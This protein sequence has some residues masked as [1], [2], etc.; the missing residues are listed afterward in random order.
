MAVSRVGQVQLLCDFGSADQSSS[1]AGL[2]DEHREGGG[3]LRLSRYLRLQP[4]IFGW[5]QSGVQVVDWREARNFF[6]VAMVC[7]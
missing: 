1:H 7:Y 4:Q 3:G 5:P 6:G 2:L